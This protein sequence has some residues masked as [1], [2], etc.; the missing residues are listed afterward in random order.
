MTFTDYEKVVTT[1]CTSFAAD[2]R[3]ESEDCK[4]ESIGGYSTYT[5]TRYVSKPVRYTAKIEMPLD[6]FC[7]MAD[8]A[9]KAHAEA[10]VRDK[11][12]SVKTA[13]EH[14][15]FLLLLAQQEEK[16]AGL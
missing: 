11:V 4:V 15:Q 10:I 5:H 13:Y 16:W 14:Y 9:A 1:F 6:E 3:I 8:V 2:V 7:S 12:A